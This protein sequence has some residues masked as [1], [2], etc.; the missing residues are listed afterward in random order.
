M[1]P[2][3]TLEDGD[4]QEEKPAGNDSILA[5]A[6]AAL[7][8][9]A[10]ESNASSEAATEAAPTPQPDLEAPPKPSPAPV[11]EAPPSED[12]A[13]AAKR[14]AAMELARRLASGDVDAAAAA[15]LSA[16]VNSSAASAGTESQQQHVMIA[17]T[18][19]FSGTLRPGQQVHVLGPKYETSK[20][21]EHH[22][23]VTIE[24]L[25][26]IMGRELIEVQSA[27]AGAVVGILGL[28]G[29]VLKTVT[30]SS[31]SHCP[32]LARSNT[33]AKPIVRVVL[34]AVNIIDLPR[35][36]AGMKL[37]YQADPCCE[38]LVQGSGEHVLVCAG[39]VHVERCVVDL[40]ERFCPGVKFT[41]SKPIIPLRETVVVPPT[42]DMT[43][44]AINTTTNAVNHTLA[45]SHYLLEKETEAENGVVTVAT[46]NNALEF[47]VRALP[48]P[49]AVVDLLTK[50]EQLLQ[51]LYEN[52]SSLFATVD[53]AA[54][55]SGAAA[56]TA[57][58]S[59]PAANE[60]LHGAG[61]ALF[62]QLKDA[63]GEAGSAWAGA[64]ERIIAFG[65]R[66]SGPNVILNPAAGEPIASPFFAALLPGSSAAVPLAP[67]ASWQ[68]NVDVGF[69]L[70]TASG[71]LAEEPMIGV[72]FV[73]ESVRIGMLAAADD[74]G[75]TDVSGAA[76]AA[77]DVTIAYTA[78]EVISAIKEALKWAFLAQPV[79]LM[80]AFYLCEMVVKA[81][82][83][84]KVYAVLSKRNSKI[85]S[86]EMNESGDFLLQALVPVTHS[87]GFAE[88]VRRK[89][90]GLASPQLFFDSW[91]VVHHD[92]FWQPSTQSE[93]DY[94]GD[95]GDAP[96]PAFELLNNVRN[97]KGLF[98]KR[99][100]VVSAEKQRTL[101]MNK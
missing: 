34:D 66:Q 10:V 22:E 50:E 74:D 59:A 1:T 78:G 9:T 62:Q 17:Y 45:R 18:R 29:H 14:H 94:Y 87:F 7:P 68:Q 73:V 4:A 77:A 54:G 35:L 43:G 99:N 12:A 20:P 83:L 47:K 93:L 81:A 76:A 30:L 5:W 2:P 55:A 60:S 97:R 58:Q 38:V 89:S 80:T 79:R 61:A 6:A 39:E 53:G 8:Q 95:L 25:F 63:F 40:R 37:L 56:S 75:G 98:V 13:A 33:N 101:G 85:L 65:P 36:K 91:R 16:S 31:T 26:I 90:S 28:E 86:E 27:P 15:R 96:N 82:S 92:P 72:A 46:P 41:V 69:Q 52:R 44:E 19:V 49:A 42:T 57:A 84:G 88:D 21:D 70:M 11:P 67:T 32:S 51:Q 24:R 48:L 64:E 71:P 23:V 100:L 3:M